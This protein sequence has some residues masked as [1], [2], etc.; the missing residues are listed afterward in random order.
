MV[1]RTEF[2]RVLESASKPEDRILLL[3]A[4]LGKALGGPQH[5]TVVGGSAI[6]VRTRGA[7]VSG[8]IDLVGRRKR[9]EPVLRGWGF[10]REKCAD[11][12]RAYWT[13]ADLGLAIDIID[14]PDY[15]GL[16]AGIETIATPSGPTRIA[17]VEDL[18]IRRLV[19]WKATGERGFLDQAVLLLQENEDR[20]DQVY[21]GASVKWEGVED[22][23][24][25]AKSLAGQ[26]GQGGPRPD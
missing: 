23:L 8:D 20:I 17:A 22:V 10:Q 15:V 11:D 9:I 12:T 26:L 19:R 2:E 7:Y 5:V 4:L 21:L 24:A 18:V 25:L 3:G 14:R 6:S 13:R 16:E 1:S